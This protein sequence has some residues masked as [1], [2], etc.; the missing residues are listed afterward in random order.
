MSPVI[1]GCRNVM[2]HCC[3][4][5]EG[6]RSVKSKVLITTR[7][8]SGYVVAFSTKNMSVWCGRNTHLVLFTITGTRLDS[9]VYS[10][11]PAVVLW[12]LYYR[13]VYRLFMC[14]RLLG[15]FLCFAWEWS[16]CFY[17]RMSPPQNLLVLLWQWI[18]ESLGARLWNALTWGY[19]VTS[20]KHR[21]K[22]DVNALWPQSNY[23]M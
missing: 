23:A 2:P 3:C 15:T 17:L 19:W 20:V 7:I 1:G 14:V 9:N 12:L 11:H 10:L 16:F 13:C 6:L 22:S 18:Q 5:R 8:L 4:S 21:E